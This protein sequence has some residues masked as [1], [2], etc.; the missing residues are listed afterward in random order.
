MRFEGKHRFVKEVVRSA[1]NF[2]NVALTLA[3][4]HQK[5][6]AYHLDASAFFRQSVEMD[7]VTTALITSYPENVQQ[8]FYQIAPQLAT[9]LVPSSVFV[10]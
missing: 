5:M 2:R 1:H 4:K 8:T 7:K 6:M 10:D 9:V 3:V